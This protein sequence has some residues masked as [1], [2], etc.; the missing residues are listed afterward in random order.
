MCRPEWNCVWAPWLSSVVYIER[1]T[2]MSSMQPPMC[3]TQ[4]L[5][6]DAG[7]AVLLEADL[8]RI[9]LV[10]LLAVGVV[11]DGDAGQLELLGVLRVGE[12]RLG[13]RSCRAYFVSSG[14]GSKRLHVR[15]A[16]VHEQPDHAL[17]LRRE[18]RL[19]VRRLPARRRG[20]RA[21]WEL[22]AT[23][24]RPVADWPGRS[25]G[26][27]YKSFPCCGPIR[28]RRSKYVLCRK[29]FNVQIVG[30]TVIVIR[31]LLWPAKEEF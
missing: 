24:N 15:H 12:R 1:T 2:A 6:F 11:D 25:G 17:G 18:V 19:P 21:A 26:C 10:P 29:R 30:G 3:G 13:D 20:I 22:S 31:T 28:L 5:T 16:A 9:E 8:Q 23:L 14:L 7:L 4:S 27:N